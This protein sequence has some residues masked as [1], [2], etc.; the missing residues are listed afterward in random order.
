MT[1]PYFILGVLLALLG[2]TLT[3]CYRFPISPNSRFRVDNKELPQG[4]YE[5][6]PEYVPCLGGLRSRVY[7]P[8]D[9]IEVIDV[10]VP[11]DEVV[12]E[13]LSNFNA[14]GAPIIHNN[15]KVQIEAW[16]YGNN[17]E[18][19]GYAKLLG[20]IVSYGEPVSY[21]V[22][23]YLPHENLYFCP[24]STRVEANPILLEERGN[25]PCIG[26]LY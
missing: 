25:P 1:K 3:S 9:N 19:I 14:R 26:F 10:T 5:V 18:E 6:L 8:E 21:S 4:F 24:Y 7:F 2:L 17:E 22:S 11:T 12:V 23:V 13:N 16:C 15:M 20:R